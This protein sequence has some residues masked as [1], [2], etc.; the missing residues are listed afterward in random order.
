MK[1]LLH[2]PCINEKY[3]GTVI[4]STKLH[5][6]MYNEAFHKFIHSRKGLLYLLSNYDGKA[7]LI[8]SM[9]DAY[10]KLR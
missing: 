7:D 4:Q 2:C 6:T 8:K 1:K 9:Q 5:R 3:C 10:H